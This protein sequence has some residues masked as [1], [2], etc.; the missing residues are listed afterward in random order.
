S[1]DLDGRR[2]RRLGMDDEGFVVDGA[3]QV[4]IAR[5]Q[6]S[7]IGARLRLDDHHDV[8]L[9]V[10]LA[11]RNAQGQ[12]AVAA[13]AFAGLNRVHGF[14]SLDSGCRHPLLPPPQGGREWSNTKS[15]NRII[16]LSTPGMW[17]LVKKQPLRTASCE[18][19]RI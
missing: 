18:N 19:G 10:R 8:E 2:Q 12:G 3:E 16:R 14:F 4:K 1:F 6:P 13:G 15:T 7:R 17:V 9:G 5:W 11:E